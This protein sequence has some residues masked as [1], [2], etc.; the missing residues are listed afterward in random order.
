MFELI[1]RIKS[2][3]SH[4]VPPSAIIFGAAA[5]TILANTPLVLIFCYADKLGPLWMV[6]L[7][8]YFGCFILLYA[9]IIKPR[10][11][12]RLRYLLGDEDFYLLFPSELKRELRRLRREQ[13]RLDR[14]QR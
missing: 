4:N 6:L 3:K 1:R 11:M 9:S 8:A 2:I 7:A 14:Q 5:F 10:E 12:A 13:K